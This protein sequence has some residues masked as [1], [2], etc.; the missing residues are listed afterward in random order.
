MDTPLFNQNWMYEEHRPE[1]V[2][3][4]FTGKAAMLPP[5]DENGLNIHV[6]GDPCIFQ[7]PDAYPGT[8]PDGLQQEVD[9]LRTALVYG[10]RVTLFSSR[11][12]EFLAGCRNGYIDENFVNNRYFQEIESVAKSGH[13][14]IFASKNCFSP[15][16]FNS[17]MACHGEYEWTLNQVARDKSALPMFGECV[18]KCVFHPTPYFGAGIMADAD[19][20]CRYQEANTDN[21]RI[22]DAPSFDSKHANI[23]KQILK[24]IPQFHNANLTEIVDIRNELLKPLIRFRSA[25]VK[26]TQ[27]IKSFPG[28]SSYENEVKSLIVRDVEPTLLEIEDAVKSNSLMGVLAG[29]VDKPV[30]LAAHSAVGIALSHIPF[31]PS[32][33]AL[34]VGTAVGSMGAIRGASKEWAQ[35]AKAIEANHMYFYYQLRKRFTAR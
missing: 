35:K 28:D 5:K 1:F 20:I 11:L 30:E 25:M 7:H 18:R 9:M 33:I 10:D 16:D 24:R 34:G 29:L 32:P 15:D 17:G 8:L 13:V 3:N 23:V 12:D 26:I 4:F 14:S 21:Y 19:W 31:L 27:D 22:T 2:S 6:A